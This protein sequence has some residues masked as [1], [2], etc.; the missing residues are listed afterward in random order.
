MAIIKKNNPRQKR[1][2]RVRKKIFGTAQRPR[3][4][5]YRSLR[6]ISAQAIDDA[7]GHTLCAFSSSS[8]DFKNQ[9]KYAGNISAATS[10]GEAFGAKLK[11]LGIQ[12][13]VFD[14]GGFLYHG[15][16]KAFADGARKAGIQF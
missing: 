4:A 14:R 10:A 3:V 12:Q 8:N 16:V 13:I 5:I 2:I 6:H 15:R 1:H 9:T 7:Q 11:E